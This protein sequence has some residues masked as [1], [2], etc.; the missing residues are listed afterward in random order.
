MADLGRP[1]TY[2]EEILTQSQAYLA[3]CEDEEVER[4][5]DDRPVYS[6][7]VKLPTIEGLTRSGRDMISV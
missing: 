7:K 2:S 3:S 4:G 6:I 1:S 5:S